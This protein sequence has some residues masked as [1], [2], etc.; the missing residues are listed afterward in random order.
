M[1]TWIGIAGIGCAII[2]ASAAISV[3]IVRTCISSKASMS[4]SPRWFIC[5]DD[6]NASRSGYKRLVPAQI[7]IISGVPESGE[8]SIGKGTDAEML[9]DND[10]KTLAAPGNR[11]LDY[12]M[13]MAEPQTIRRA[14]ITW[15]DYG[16]NENYIKSWSIEATMDGKEWKTIASGAS[17][18]NSE[19]LVNETFPASAVRLRAR[20]D[21]DWIG[22]YEIELIGRPL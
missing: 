13:T 2:A 12:I 19:T 1:K 21:K 6:L 18:R 14:V 16:I 17:P 15:G 11:E 3:G 22:A 8:Y 9:V 4:I 5:G 7:S 10:K 20:S